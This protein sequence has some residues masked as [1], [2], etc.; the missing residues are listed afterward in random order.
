MCIF[1]SF[2]YGLLYLFLTAYP[3]IFQQIHGMNPGVSGLPFLAVIIGELLAGLFFYARQPWLMR[4]II[5]NK[6]DLVP[7]WLLLTAI[8]GSVSFSAG[9]FWLGW[10]GYKRDLHWMLPTVSGLLTGFGLITMFLPSI[11]YCVQ[12]RRERYL[13]L[14]LVLIS[15]MLMQNC[16]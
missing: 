12:I 15:I 4:K 14:S 7:E 10:T 6:G 5:A 16:C 1:G 3:I 11:Q 13:T 8:P 2:V 9:L